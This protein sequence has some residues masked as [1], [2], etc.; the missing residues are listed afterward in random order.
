ML[1]K[2]LHQNLHLS[3]SFVTMIM[4]LGKQITCLV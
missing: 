2:L 4:Q 3:F 1:S